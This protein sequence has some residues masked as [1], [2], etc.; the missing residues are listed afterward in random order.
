MSTVVEDPAGVALP[1]SRTYLKTR[2]VVDYQDEIKAIDDML[3]D[4]KSKIENRADMNQ[5]VQQLRQTLAHGAPPDTTPDQ[6]TAL[7]KEEA[8]LREEIKSE[9]LSQEE[10]RKCPPG[11]IGAE[12]KFQRR[13][14]AKIIR[15]KNIMRTLHK[16][17][18]DPDI[19]NM[20]KFRGKVNRLNMD[21]AVIPG[22]Q[23]FLSPDT[24]AYKDGY[25]KIWPS[26]ASAR[27]QE[28]ESRLA[29]LEKMIGGQSKKTSE[30]QS[31][32]SV[33]EVSDEDRPFVET[34]AC[35]RV[36][37]AKAQHRAT[38]GKN[39][40]ERGCAKCKEIKGE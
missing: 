4:G 21:N 19:S 27:V 38:F 30:K 20:E 26:E 9:M 34:A 16:G 10:L 3:N 15:W 36:I 29:E 8:S 39:G 1:T 2:Q 22:K 18:D 7:A 35:G 17:D 37:R 11:A 25:E 32:E 33:K 6:R 28:L 24:Q 40:H 14:K 31:G 5:R 13:N 12:L 23:H